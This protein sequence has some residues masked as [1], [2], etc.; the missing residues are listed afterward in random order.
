MPVNFATDK[1]VITKWPGDR[2]DSDAWVTPEALDAHI[3]KVER[4]GGTV[5][6]INGKRYEGREAE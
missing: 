4:E 6:T 1:H 3:A 2:P 5:Y